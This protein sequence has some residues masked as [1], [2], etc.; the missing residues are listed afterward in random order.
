[1]GNLYI[2]ITLTLII[3]TV[4]CKSLSP[5]YTEVHVYSFIWRSTAMYNLSTKDIIESCVDSEGNMKKA[6]VVFDSVFASD[7]PLFLN[8]L[9]LVKKDDL[10]ADANSNELDIRLVCFISKSNSSIVDTLSFS[11][12]GYMMFNSKIYNYNKSYLRT[13]IT[14]LPVIHQ[15]SILASGKLE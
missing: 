3:S 11:T 7:L 2:V 9:D 5:N 1:M 13:L 12:N 8:I 14:Y 4:S 6:G 10:K 15:K